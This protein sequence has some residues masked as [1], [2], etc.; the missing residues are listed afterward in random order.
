MM[1]SPLGALGGYSLCMIGLNNYYRK[2]KSKM[3]K[4]S[5]TLTSVFSKNSPNTIIIDEELPAKHSSEN[6]S[7]KKIK[8]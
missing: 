8:N 1:L 7:R 3:K 6:S 5:K 4:I 2:Q